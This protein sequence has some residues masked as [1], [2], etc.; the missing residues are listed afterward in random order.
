[1]YTTILCMSIHGG[2]VANALG[3]IA[4][5]HD[6]YEIYFLESIQPPAQRDLKWSV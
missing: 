5:G 3:C 1:M 4:R 2:Q 6:I